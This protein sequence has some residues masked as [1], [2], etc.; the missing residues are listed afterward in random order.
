RST[1]LFA[2]GPGRAVI[3]RGVLSSVAVIMKSSKLLANLLIGQRL[4][5]SSSRRADLGARRRTYP[6]CALPVGGLLVYAVEIWA[7]FGGRREVNWAVVNRHF[8]FQRTL[9]SRESSRIIPRSASSLRTR[10][11]VAKSRRARAALRSATS[12]SIS[13][14]LRS[15]SAWLRPRALSLPA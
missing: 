5:W 6:L 8:R 1:M 11:L 2:L 3:S 7:Y 13:A 4:L 14:S 9:P 10:S 15:P 12:F